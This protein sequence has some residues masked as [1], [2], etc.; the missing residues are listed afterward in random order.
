MS[1]HVAVRRPAVEEVEG[2][3]AQLVAEVGLLASPRAQRCTIG[4]GDLALDEHRVGPL[5]QD[6]AD[7]EQRRA[8]L[9]GVRAHERGSLLSCSF[10]PP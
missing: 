9:V 4:L 7:R 5:L 3:E 6:L 8:A 10:Q 2:E 1:L